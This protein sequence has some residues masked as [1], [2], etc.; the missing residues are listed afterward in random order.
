MNGIYIEKEDNDILKQEY[1]DGT[2]KIRKNMVLR[3]YYKYVPARKNF[4]GGRV[5]ALKSAKEYI[6][7]FRKDKNTEHL[8]DAMSYAQI[9]V[10]V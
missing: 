3:S 2:D 10:S 5:D 8:I 7:A 6:E 1:C 9:Y 4:G